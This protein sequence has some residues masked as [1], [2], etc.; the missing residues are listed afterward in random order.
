MRTLGILGGMAWPSTADAYR[1][2][3]TEVGRRVGGIASAPLIIWSFD[4]AEVE[5]LQADGDWDGAGRLLAGAAQR[6]EAAGAQGLLLCTNTMH[7]VAPA[8]EAAT[9]IPLL[10]IA[11][12]TAAA[13]QRDGVRRVGLLGT[14]FTME[15]TFYRSRLEA[16]GLEVVV[17]PA[18]QRELVHR[19]IY[20]ELVK[21]V[22][23]D[24]SRAAYLEVVAALEDDGVEG[25]VAGCTEIELLIT[26]DDVGVLYPTTLIHAQAAADW[27]IG[28][29]PPGS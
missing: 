3:N 18:A 12:A 26:A 16:H 25:V 10:H 29:P 23:R 6:L 27:I 21:G 13:I 22:I 20:S 8:I 15:D 19:V 7:K 17:P 24:D 14:R 4:F 1:L 11:D 2:I 9:S 5:R 28:A